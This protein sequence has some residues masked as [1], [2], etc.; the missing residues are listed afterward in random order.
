MHTRTFMS[1]HILSHPHQHTYTHIHTFTHKRPILLKILE[2]RRC[3]SMFLILIFGTSSPSHH[4]VK[5]IISVNTSVS[6][7]PGAM[8][9]IGAI[10][11]ILVNNSFVISR[12]EAN[13]TW[14]HGWLCGR[15][16]KIAV[17]LV[18]LMDFFPLSVRRPYWL[19]CLDV[20]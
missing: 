8:T 20:L 10:K 15:D 16:R 9:A 6:S 1:T 18:G 13:G 5:K 3:F 4:I 12:H 11:P 19:S 2:R 14:Q 7:S 17:S